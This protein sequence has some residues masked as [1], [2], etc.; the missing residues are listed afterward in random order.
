M[1]ILDF[2]MPIVAFLVVCLLFSIPVVWVLFFNAALTGTVLEMIQNYMQKRRPAR[3]PVI[4][5]YKPKTAKLKKFGLPAKAWLALAIVAVPIVLAAG[6]AIYSFSSY[7]PVVTQVAAVVPPAPP[8]AE[9][10]TDVSIE[11]GEKVFATNCAVCHQATGVGVEG[12]FPPLSNSEWLKDPE[13]VVKIVHNGLAGPISVL[14]K[15]FNSAMPGFGSVFSPAETAAVVNYVRNSWQ[16]KGKY[17]DQI[18]LA[19]VEGVIEKIGAKADA[20]QASELAGK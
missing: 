1:A 4:F 2:I 18:D 7:Q 17:P 16:N 3:K 15:N 10:S 13:V 14:G 12:A 6:L 9:G 19:F 11:A 20:Y 8:S 5:E